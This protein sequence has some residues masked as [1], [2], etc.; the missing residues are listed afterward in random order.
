MIQ[1]NIQQF[2]T[3]QTP[4][5]DKQGNIT[6]IWQKFFASVWNR[7]GGA[8]GS[9]GYFAYVNGTTDQV[10]NVA[11]AVTPTE[12]TPLSQAQSIVRTLAGSASA[13]VTLTASPMTWTAP[14]NGSISLGGD[15]IQSVSLMRGTGITTISRHYGLLPVRSGDQLTINY[16]GTPVLTWLPD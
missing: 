14:A 13:A 8:N 9:N 5:V 3:P 10:F 6:K 7:T 15:G 11:V 1:P 12:A 4:V 16:I 2:P